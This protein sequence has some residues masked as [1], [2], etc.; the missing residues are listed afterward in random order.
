MFPQEPTGLDGASPCQEHASGVAPGARAEQVFGS[1][2]ERSNLPDG[3]DMILDKILGYV[4]TWFLDVFGICWDMLGYRVEWFL[5]SFWM[6]DKPRFFFLRN[7]HDFF[8]ASVLFFTPS[9]QH[10]HEKF[11]GG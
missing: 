9:N 10:D 4:G 3:W 1:L 6:R 8:F 5:L 7:G 11:A 2:A